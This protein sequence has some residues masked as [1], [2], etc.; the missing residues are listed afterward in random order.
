MA[1]VF[2]VLLLLIN[3]S[4]SS[5]FELS[6]MRSSMDD[7]LPEDVI[8][9][10][11]SPHIFHCIEKCKELSNP[12]ACNSIKFD[13]I[14]STCVLAY[15]VIA[16]DCSSQ[17][18]EAQTT[19]GISTVWVTEDVAASCNSNTDDASGKYFSNSSS[20]WECLTKTLFSSFTPCLYKHYLLQDVMIRNFNVVTENASLSNGDVTTM[21]IVVITATNKIVL[22][23]SLFLQKQNFIFL[24]KF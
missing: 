10:I 15:R 5:R 21:M 4:K 14:T 12:S 23:I 20:I 9:S 17:Q 16:D 11:T 6:S 8:R 19:L 7:I 24:Y 1:P 2:G 22:C 13:P 3:Y 18:G